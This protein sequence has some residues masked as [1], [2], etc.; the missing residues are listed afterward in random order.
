MTARRHDSA[1]GGMRMSVATAIP[2]AR[3]NDL[4]Q[5]VRLGALGSRT[6]RSGAPVDIGLLRLRIRSAASP[7]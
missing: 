1:G 3:A 7:A 2:A 5:S 6:A 4:T